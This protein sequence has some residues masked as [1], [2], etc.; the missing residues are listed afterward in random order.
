MAFPA[1]PRRD[2]PQAVV[3]RRGTM[4]ET[5]H[6]SDIVVPDLKVSRQSDISVSLWDYAALFGATSE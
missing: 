5:H 1:A 3:S 6:L 2:G 4:S